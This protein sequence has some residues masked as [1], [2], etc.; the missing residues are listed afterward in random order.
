MGLAVAVGVALLGRS[1]SSWPASAAPMVLVVLVVAAA[2]VELFGV[3]RQVGYEPVT[4]A[5]IVAVAGLV[6]G[7]Y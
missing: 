4:L 6:L 2:A 3:L 7:A 5:G 1:S